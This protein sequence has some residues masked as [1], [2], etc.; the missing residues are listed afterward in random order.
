MTA[1][2]HAGRAEEAHAFDV[3]GDDVDEPQLDVE[4]FLDGDA[5]D[6]PA[7]GI[8]V[9]AAIEVEKLD[10]LRGHY[11]RLTTAAILRR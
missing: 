5:F 3:V 7:G 2:A 1:D 11:R 8:D 6:E 10:C 4:V 9:R